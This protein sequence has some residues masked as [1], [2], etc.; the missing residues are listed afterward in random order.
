MFTRGHYDVAEY[1]LSLEIA[2]ALHD[3]VHSRVPEIQKNVARL[4]LLN[5]EVG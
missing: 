4:S 3:A 2:M 1:V 5:Q